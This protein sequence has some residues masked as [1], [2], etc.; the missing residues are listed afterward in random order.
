MAMV[1]QGLEWEKCLIYLDDI[2][3]FST[4][5]DQHLKDLTLVFDRFR[6]SNLKLKPSKCQFGKKHLK[7]LGHIIS[8]EG[9]Q[10]DADKTMAI[11]KFARP[12]T[13]K[14]VASFLGLAGYYHKFV[15]NFSNL[16][17]P[18]NNLKRKDVP[19]VWTDECQR[20][21]EIIKNVLCKTPL[22]IYPDFS[23]PF[24]L[25][26]DAS[27]FAL[28]AVLSQKTEKGVKP[29]A[30]ASRAL[31]P[32]QRR[33]HTIEKESLAIKWAA[34]H[35]RHYLYG[36]KFHV[37]TDHKPLK[38]LF[39]TPPKNSRI[40]QWRNELLLEFGGFDIQY[41]PGHENGN[42]DGLSRDPN[43]EPDDTDEPEASL[44]EQ[45]QD[46]RLL[47]AITQ[48]HHKDDVPCD[49]LGEIQNKDPGLTPMINYLSRD[50][51]PTDDA[52]A[53]KIM[54]SAPIYHIEEG[55][56]YVNSCHGRGEEL[57]PVVPKEL[58]PTILRIEHEGRFAAHPGINK[59]FCNI[60]RKYFWK[61]I[62]Q[63]V[64]DYVLNCD[65]C[66]TRKDPPKRGR[67]PLRPITPIGKPMHRLHVDIMK[68]GKTSA[69]GN[70]YFIGFI[71][72][73]TKFV[74][75]FAAPNQT[76]ETCAKLFVTG[77]L[78]N[79]GAP[80]ELISDQGRQFMSYLY[81]DIC[82][83]TG[84]FKKET[85]TYHP[86]ANGEI[87]RFHK[88]LQNMLALNIPNRDHS[89]WDDAL[90]ICLMAYNASVHTS[91][92]ETPF[93]LMHGFDPQLPDDPAIL[94]TTSTLYDTPES[95]KT[96]VISTLQNVWT[97]CANTIEQAQERQKRQ[98]DKKSRDP[99]F[100]NQELVWV[101]HPIISKQ[102]S[103]K[104]AHKWHGP[105]RIIEVREP[106]LRVQLISRPNTNIHTIHFNQAKICKGPRTPPLYT[107]DP[108]DRVLMG[109]PNIDAEVS[110]DEDPIGGPP[111]IIVDTP[112][113]TSNDPDQ[114]NLL[115]DSPQN[116]P[117][118]SQTV[119]I[120]PHE[121]N[122]EP[123]V[124]PAPSSTN[125]TSRNQVPVTVFPSTSVFAGHPVDTLTARTKSVTALKSKQQ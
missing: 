31:L 21:F 29:I 8:A 107:F 4:D 83:L 60:Q 82:A 13:V 35:F 124:L 113:I 125:D 49:R 30:Y 64:K 39:N 28:G 52:A 23:K 98:Y 54:L 79:Y 40:A 88:T 41:R 63:D 57:R 7:Y 85:V 71:D 25:Q 121:N 70:K 108:L 97:Q 15:P 50:D 2:L 99:K 37:E 96:F 72:A 65:A 45:L 27:G 44:E 16:A 66:Q 48:S 87:E 6:T 94:N 75:G 104:L 74:I 102:D 109:D 42:A 95:Y 110:D 78:C 73:F 81:K 46:V 62:R 9:V 12:K 1:L 106:N 117:V 123:C 120:R 5:F 91:T 76:A 86:Q 89:R 19:F 114:E 92:S 101:H 111:I 51:L 119:A 100:Q 36:H 17:E 80:Q 26:T 69:N 84:T 103:H 43:H 59:T 58:I 77:V 105:Y 18:F 61:G 53:R 112:L 32:Y 67:C 56:L 22:L 47:A 33:Y 122:D 24:I 68:I 20:N 34:L 115:A 90:P 116:S 55:I 3:V 10:P 11:E 38:A 118:T 14:Q 93:Y